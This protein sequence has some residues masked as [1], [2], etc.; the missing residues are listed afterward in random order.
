MPSQGTCNL[1][2]FSF[3]KLFP[4]MQKM[5]R[6]QHWTDCSLTIRWSSSPHKSGSQGWVHSWLGMGLTAGVRDQRLPPTF[7]SDQ[8]VW[9]ITPSSKDICSQARAGCVA[10]GRSESLGRW[11]ESYL[12]QLNG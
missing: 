5:G 11:K 12:P 4:Q 3:L 8:R 9:L 2:L 6:T 1:N 10:A 7:S